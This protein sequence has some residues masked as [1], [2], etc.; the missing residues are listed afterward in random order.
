MLLPS[1]NLKWE[2]T[3]NTDDCSFV[4]RNQSEN[5]QKCR[6][7]RCPYLNLFVQDSWQSWMW[8]GRNLWTF[9]CLSDLVLI[10]A[11]E[12][13]VSPDCHTCRW[14]SVQAHHQSNHWFF[15][16]F[17]QNSKMRCCKWLQPDFFHSA[18]FNYTA[19]LSKSKTCKI[20]WD[21]SS[22]SD[23]LIFLW[24]SE[25][26]TVTER[27]VISQWFYQV[28]GHFVWYSQSTFN[29]IPSHHTTQILS[30][31]RMTK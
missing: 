15:T 23:W 19:S 3:I 31:V 22:I 30:T 5:S 4:V 1:L 17:T 29:D 18:N 28:V 13:E 27:A 14:N 9:R 10:W 12:L 24:F 7:K 20:I 16:P 26:R 25:L 8:T 6:K 21:T 2:K 11:E